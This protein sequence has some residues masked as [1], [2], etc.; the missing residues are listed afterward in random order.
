VSDFEA[1]F[2]ASGIGD[3]VDHFGTAVVY[4]IGGTPVVPSPKVSPIARGFGSLSIESRAAG[5]ALEVLVDRADVPTVTPNSDSIDVP[6]AWL[7]KVG[8][9]TTT[10][11]VS[12]IVDADDRGSWRLTLGEGR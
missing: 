5:S 11:V 4:R 3:L 6:N 10:L 1:D 2:A 9:G 12:S 8:S 7:G